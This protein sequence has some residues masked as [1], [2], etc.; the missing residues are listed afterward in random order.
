MQ[1]L[2]VTFSNVFYRGDKSF[3]VFLCV[4]ASDSKNGPKKNTHGYLFDSERRYRTFIIKHVRVNIR[5][6]REILKYR[7]SFNEYNII[8]KETL[9]ENNII[10]IDSCLFIPSFL[11]II[12]FLLLF[13]CISFQVLTF[14]GGYL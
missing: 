11:S 3:L 10:Y 13:D 9:P 7:A 6:A 12:I 14:W 5:I 4:N 8:T 1:N 2:S